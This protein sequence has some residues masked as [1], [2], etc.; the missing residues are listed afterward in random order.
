MIFI[1]IFVIVI[2]LLVHSNFAEINIISGN[3]S[4]SLT[5]YK[6]HIVSFM[7]YAIG[8]GVLLISLFDYLSSEKIFVAPSYLYI[9]TLI[10]ILIIIAVSFVNLYL[11]NKNKL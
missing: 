9:A 1:G 11:A 3:D 10:F 4:E 8:A 5:R 6:R 7:I 2:G